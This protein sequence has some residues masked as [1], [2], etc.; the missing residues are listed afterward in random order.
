MRLTRV[1]TAVVFAAVLAVTILFRVSVKQDST[2]PTITLSQNKIQAECSVSDETL[3][4]YVTAYDEKD[5]DLTDKVFI[6]NISQF[7]S[8]GVSTVTFCVSDN[9]N[10]VA[11]ATA[12]LEFTDYE[13]PELILKDDLVFSENAAV[14]V[15]GCVEVED[16]F[17]GDITD[18]LSVIADDSAEESSS[19]PITF[20]VT[21]SKGFTYSW[22]I[23]AIRVQ[24]YT[25]NSN[26]TVN[27]DNH[28]L[29][30]SVGSKKPNFK[31]LVKSIK[32]MGK[33]FDNGIVVIDDS[34]LDMSEAGT[35]NVWIDLYTENE[36]TDKN[37]GRERV[38]RERLIVICEEK[39]K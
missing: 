29:E 1:L 12:T 22:V 4:S 3:L 2:K 38:T 11:K 7:I 33:A 36:K 9:D 37:G 19:I 17:D 6:E 27:V 20:K 34:E 13:R 32:Y 24:E 14:N 39:S 26:Y 16:K 15:V 21:N 10:N 23:E 18:R 31:N 5:G 30:L 28:L 8:E 25:L 35:Y